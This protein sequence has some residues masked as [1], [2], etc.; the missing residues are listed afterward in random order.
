MI[1]YLDMTFCTQE[2]AQCCQKGNTCER[3]WNALR[4]Q[5]ADAWW[6]GCKGTAP[7]CFFVGIPSCFRGIKEKV[8]EA[9]MKPLRDEE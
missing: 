7:V 1:C 2:V 8:C 9:I 3:A 4:Q 6:S 5:A